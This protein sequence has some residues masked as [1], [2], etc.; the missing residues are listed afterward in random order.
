MLRFHDVEFLR[1]P[2]PI[3]LAKQVFD[4]ALYDKLART[5]PLEKHFKYMNGA[6]SKYS[7]SEVNKPD[8]YSYFLARNEPWRQFY[9]YIKSKQFVVDVA[10]VLRL[11]GLDVLNGTFKTRFEFS[12]LPG[13]GGMLFPHTDIPSKVVTLILPMHRGEWQTAWGGGTDVLK[14]KFTDKE[15]RDYKMPLSDFDVVRTFECE[16]NQCVIFIKN[17]VSWHSVGPTKGP[18]DS[19]R[20]TLTVNIEKV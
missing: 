9:K 1:E 3:G 8:V 4:P 2:Y 13:K 19:F 17:N 7:L 5:F 12:S 11:Q 20:R 18:K 16:P 6:Y 15:Y 10:Q 14:P